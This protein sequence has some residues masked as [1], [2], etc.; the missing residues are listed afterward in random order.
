MDVS[1]GVAVQGAIRPAAGDL[2]VVPIDAI[3]VISFT[4]PAGPDGTVTI[5]GLGTGLP[6][7]PGVDST[8]YAVRGSE[9]Y[10][11]LVQTLTLE[12]VKGNGQVEP[13]T[14]AG[15][16]APV[17][18]WTINSA[19]DANPAAQLAMLTWQPTPATK[20][21]E[22]TDRLVE[23]IT[24]RWGSG[25]HT[26]RTARRG[27]VD[28]QARS[29]RALGH[30]WD[31]EG[32]AWP[33]PPG[34]QRSSGP[35]TGLRVTEPWRTGDPTVDMLRG[36][37]P[38]WVT[39]G[40]V[41]CHRTKP[42]PDLTHLTHLGST[43][44]SPVATRA[45]L[46]AV[47][48]RA[49]AGPRVVVGG[50]G[51]LDGRTK[52]GELLPVDDVVRSIVAPHADSLDVRVSAAF[53]AK[54]TAAMTGLQ[55][56]AAGS[57]ANLLDIARSA[58]Q[59]AAISR[60]AMD[61]ALQNVS[62][63][64]HLTPPGAATPG[65]TTTPGTG[66][67]TGA[68]RCPVKSLLS[69][70]Y[71]LGRVT[72]FPD[73]AIRKQLELAGLKDEDLE[74]VNRIQIHS[75]PYAAL[76]V[77][78]F[79]PPGGRQKFVPVVARVLAADG[80]ELDR[81]AVAATDLLSQGR[82]LPTHWTD[83][84]G[85]WGNDIDDLVRSAQE[86]AM[87]VAYLE[88]PKHLD[89][90]LVELGVPLKATLQT[91]LSYATAATNGNGTAP[92]AYFLA[93]TS[94]VTG[95]E[96]ARSDWD[97]TQ[98]A[99]DRTQLTNAVGPAASDNAL[100]KADSTYRITATWAADRAGDGAT[101]G[102]TQVFWFRTDTLAT[103]PEDPTIGSG[104][105]NPRPGLVFTDTPDATKVRLDP[106]VLVSLP[107]DQETGY[108]GREDLKLVFNTHDVDRIFAEH[109]K[110]LRLRIE[111][112]NGQHPG[113]TTTTPMPLPIT[114]GTGG[115][116]QQ[117]EGVVKS[118]W[119]KALDVAI[120]QY[121]D[122]HQAT[123]ET[124][125]VD[126][127]AMSSSHGV[128]DIQIPLDPF[129]DYLLDVEIVDAGAA[130][131]ARGPRVL[132]RHFTTGGYGTLGAFAW[133][134]SSILPTARSCEPGTFSSMLGGG[135]IGTHPLG[136]VLDAHLMSHHIEAL[137][138]PEKPRVVVFWEQSGSALPQ[139]AAVLVDAMEPLAR[140]RRYP[141]DVTDTT[142]SPP[143]Q[144][145]ILAQRDW[146]GLTTAGSTAVTD[147][148][149]APGNQR[150]FVVLAPNQRGTSLTVNLTAPA[151]PDLPFLDPGLRQAPVAEL[152]LDHAPW[153]ET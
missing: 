113:G 135:G 152:L 98:I 12:R 132:R 128:L 17:A 3:P 72:N 5:G 117:V 22:Y 103:D 111:A 46:T 125:C 55:D 50:R 122:A 75:G 99:Q 21:I 86:A 145:W 146:L 16:S 107:D 83:L 36:V 45:A 42:R 100:L 8:G 112:S 73:D 153:E 108:F 96:T 82:A 114:S 29:P 110:E 54:A 104:D 27:A 78:L 69:P 131:T 60:A 137:P 64:G 61:L 126:V 97:T 14:L 63:V 123:G 115:T 121:D 51:T 141:K 143:S 101:G 28:L 10:R 38:A 62:V 136:N 81:V 85:P 25:L 71:D 133:S 68:Q 134:L 77:L 88:L 2:P 109:G 40:T 80:T 144:R 90:E 147:I 19:T 130:D 56:L 23:D 150:A 58:G 4:V 74:L 127:D 13:V 43:V 140:S 129:M 119:H 66:P 148:V 11:Y 31:L 30:G 95:A 94:M 49:L 105:P 92:T 20:A 91:N 41:D 149:W 118:P 79:L 18:W 15:T 116:L 26:G 138:V 48:D 34:T 151:M 106:W 37:M 67:S 120:A 93:A 9:K 53:H 57:H 33:D 47:R 142:I 32:V 84:T 7:A 124:F 1:L 70:R 52:S 24:R 35:E 76:G 89:A 59:G 6:A 139:P 87:E 65:T 44:L 39:G 102:Q